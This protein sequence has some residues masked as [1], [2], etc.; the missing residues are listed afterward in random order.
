[1]G[2]VVKDDVGVAAT[3]AGTSAGIGGLTGFL[4]IVIFGQSGG[5]LA[6]LSILAASV[7]VGMLAGLISSSVVVD[8]VQLSEKMQWAVIIISSLVA[9]DLLSGLRS[10]G[11][12][13]ASDPIALICRIVRGFRVN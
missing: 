3:I 4:R 12:E 11:S 5:F 13:F 8:G 10:L 9:K 7:F 2:D 1:M 6:W